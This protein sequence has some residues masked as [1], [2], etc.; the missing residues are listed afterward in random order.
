MTQI[1]DT[2]CADTFSD[3]TATGEKLLGWTEFAVACL[4]F[5]VSHAVPVGTPIKS[6]LVAH[7]GSRGFTLLYSLLSCGV[8]AW[9]IV[10]AARAPFVPLWSWAPW[11]NGVAIV[12]M[13]GVC[14]LVAIAL[15]RPNPFSFGGPDEG[16]DPEAPGLVRWMRHPLLWALALWAGTHGVANGNLAHGILFFGSVSFALLGMKIIDRR[17]RSAQGAEWTGLWART[18]ASS[19]PVLDLKKDSARLCIGLL[20]W[21]GLILAH[22]PIIGVSPWP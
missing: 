12:V 4:V 18:R 19:S 17:Q 6:W 10:A 22:G 20:V 3:V 5:L 1:K 13:L 2:L 9:M 14:L 15:G 21:A 11:Q 7:L 8:F 16:F